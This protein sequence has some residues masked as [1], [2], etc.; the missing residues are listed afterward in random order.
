[1][2]FVIFE[3]KEFKAD[4]SCLLN[5]FHKLWSTS[6]CFFDRYFKNRRSY[7]SLNSCVPGPTR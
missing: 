5:K 7:A 6:V 1:M 3:V 4:V 2:Y